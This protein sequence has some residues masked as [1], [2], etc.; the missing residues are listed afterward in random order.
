MPVAAS[1]AGAAGARSRGTTGGSWGAY[2]WN[3]LV[4]SSELNRG[5]D[6]FELQPSAQLSANEQK[7]TDTIG[8]DGMRAKRGLSALTPAV[9]AGRIA[10]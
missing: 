10:G 9:G 7:L 5:L 8:S 2:Y 4:Y 3:G 1:A 6:I